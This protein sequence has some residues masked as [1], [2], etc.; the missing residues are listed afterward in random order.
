MQLGGGPSSHLVSH[1]LLLGNGESL[2]SQEVADA[3]NH[4]VGP[5][6]VDH[7]RKEEIGPHVKQFKLGANLGETDS[8]KVRKNS[9]AD[10]RSQHDSPVRER[11]AGQVRKNHLRRQSSE[12]KGHGEAKQDKVVVTHERAVWRKHPGTGADGEDS[13]WDPFHKHRENRKALC[14]ARTGNV[15]DAKGDVAGNQQENQHANP[16]IPERDIS[17]EVSHSLQVVAPDMCQRLRENVRPVDSRDDHDTAGNKEA[18][19][20][21]IEEAKIQRVRVVRLPRREEHGEARDKCSEDAGRR[22][23]QSHGGRFE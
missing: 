9:T 15:Q 13:H 10:Q 2:D 8:R 5:A 23:A 21:T 18:F 17:N 6:E 14:L 1:L 19:S 11:L 16:D 20:R 12:N 3:G 22:R 7:H 4:Q